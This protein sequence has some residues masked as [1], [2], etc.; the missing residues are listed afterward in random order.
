MLWSKRANTDEERRRRSARVTR[1]IRMLRGHGILHKVP[2]THRY[3]VSET[4]RQ[5]VTALLAARN[6]NAEFLT[7]NAA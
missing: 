4:G 1:Q 3:V 5:G 2:K 6:A 7:T